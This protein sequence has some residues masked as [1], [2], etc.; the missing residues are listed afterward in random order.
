MAAIDALTTAYQTEIAKISDPLTKAQAT[1]LL[2]RYIAALQK[3][4]ALEA[5]EIVSYSIAGRSFTRRDIA[6]G[7]SAINSMQ[8]DLDRMFHGTVSLVDMNVEVAEP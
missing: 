3:Q 8:G 2:E 7:Q 4:A 6:G 5:N 1:Y